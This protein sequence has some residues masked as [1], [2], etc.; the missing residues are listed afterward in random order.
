MNPLLE[1]TVATNHKILLLVESMQWEKIL[2]LANKRDSYLRQYFK[3]NPLPDDNTIISQVIIDMTQSDQKIS[4]L[5]S[6]K[7]SEL[8][9]ES[10]S[11]K[12][13]HSAIQ[14]YQLTQNRHAQSA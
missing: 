8:I 6:N 13:S 14:Q 10:L 9:K 4:E 1:K 7:K 12:N 5:I 3:L 2:V 11:L